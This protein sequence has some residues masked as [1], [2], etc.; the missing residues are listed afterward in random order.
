MRWKLGDELRRQV[1]VECAGINRRDALEIMDLVR[2]DIPML[3]QVRAQLNP[4]RRD[5]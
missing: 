4:G 5:D 2:A 1:D 3:N